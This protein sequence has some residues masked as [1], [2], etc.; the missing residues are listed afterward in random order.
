M[1]QT[2]GGGSRSVTEVDGHSCLTDAP[3]TADVRHVPA[4][5]CNI[6]NEQPSL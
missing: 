4:V 3:H 5:P 2:N 6:T 1:R